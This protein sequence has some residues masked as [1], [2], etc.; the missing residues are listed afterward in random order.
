MAVDC[1]LLTT[2]H[3][4]QFFTSR[5]RLKSRRMIDREVIR[6]LGQFDKLT[7]YRYST[8]IV[9][10]GK[11]NYALRKAVSMAKLAAIAIPTEPVRSIPRPVDLIEP[12]ARSHRNNPI[13]P[14]ALLAQ[15]REVPL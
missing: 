9:H 3:M 15:A 7:Q 4:A 11:V 1:G 13:T 8:I 2:L 14:S 6:V 5:F 10:T 12:V